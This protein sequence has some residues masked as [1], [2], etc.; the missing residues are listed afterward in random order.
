MMDIATESAI[1]RVK[2]NICM[3]IGHS[4]LG[5]EKWREYKS[6]TGHDAE[7]T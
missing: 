4:R 3:R 2:E 5:Q 1:Y 7:G 6:E